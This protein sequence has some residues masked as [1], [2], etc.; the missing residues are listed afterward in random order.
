MSGAARL[1]VHARSASAAA[2][3][4]A[5][6][7]SARASGPVEEQAGLRGRLAAEGRGVDG[8]LG[9]WRDGGD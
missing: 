7:T 6:A 2:R 4:S 5:R 1:G 3:A 8:G 9:D